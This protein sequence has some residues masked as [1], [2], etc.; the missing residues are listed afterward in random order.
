MSE[1]DKDVEIF[2]THNS[3]LVRTI[4][5][6]PALWDVIAEDNTPA[7]EDFDPVM[8][9]QVYYLVATRG[10][11]V[12]GL[13]VVHAMN[14]TIGMG[15]ANIL[16]K[17]WGEREQNK[18]LGKAAIQWIWDNTEFK[19]IVTTVPVMYKQVLAYTQ[20]IG[21]KREGVMRKGHLKNGELHDMY[22]M[23]ISKPE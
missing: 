19:K 17:Y 12:L 1:L 18:A 10:K 4:L 13:F 6:V 11:K 20:R 5:T 16:P 15:H 3:T 7:V 21:M 14:T 2:R 22:Y 23:G 8:H 9:D